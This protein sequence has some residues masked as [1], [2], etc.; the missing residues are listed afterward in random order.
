[1]P[2]TVAPDVSKAL[3]SNV[4]GTGDPAPT[5]LSPDEQRAYD[6][7]SF[8]FTQGRRLRARD[9]QSRRRRCTG[10]PTRRSLWRPGCSTTTPYSLEDIAQAFAGQP[11]RQ[12]HPRRGPRQHHDDLADEHRGLLGAP[13][14]GE[15]ARL[16]RHQGRHRA[17]RRQRLP[18]R[19]L[20][21]AAELD[22]AG[23]P[24]PHLLQRARPRQP[25]RGV[26]GAGALHA[27]SC[28]RRSGRCG[29]AADR[30][31]A[32]STAVRPDPQ[33]DA[34]DL[35]VGYV[36]VGPPDGPAVLLLHG[37]PY[38]IHSYAEVAPMLADAGYRVVVPYLRGYGTTR[39]R[40]ATTVR[41]GQ[42][43]ALAL[44]AIA[45]LDALEIP[46][47][48][49]GGFD[50]G[51][52]TAAILA[53]LW[54][55]RCTGLVSVS[56]Y[57]I[58]SREANRH[59]AAAGRRAR[60]VVPV[61]LRDRARS[62]RLRPVPARVRAAHLADRVAAVGASTTPTFDRSAA[63]FDNPDHVDIV[64]HNYRWRLGLADG[65]PR[66]RRPRATARRGARRS[67]SRRSRW[68]AT[69]TAHRIRSRGVSREVHR[70]VRASGRH[71]RRRPQPAAGGAAGV[72]RRGD[73]R[74]R[75]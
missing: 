74:R 12:P 43:A 37:W 50:W 72:R 19:A 61:L 8:L 35:N 68:R 38:D 21:G 41:N 64:I 13:V 42:Q 63:S 20:P 55:E 23:V 7:L 45:L 71:R 29:E 56:G 22:R 54:P 70:A 24:E 75:L 15:H 28:A 34:G 11:G 10:S 60:L 33:I 48:I 32:P 31:G 17:G 16:L 52:R 6:R 2:G 14:L 36:D 27:R 4:F 40:S 30:G 1:M 46:D 39:F 3:T 5:G 53:A 18:A 62:R 9:G 65:E 44:D 26:A 58:G 59:A 25:L 47:A 51:A 67:R 66:V 73:R 69:R 49:V 57:L